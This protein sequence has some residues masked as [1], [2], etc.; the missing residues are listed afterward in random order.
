ME[1]KSL[2]SLQGKYP[3]G[4]H[5]QPTGRFEPN[6]FKVQIFSN[7]DSQ[8][9]LTQKKKQRMNKDFF[10]AKSPNKGKL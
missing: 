9:V 7:N 10:R 8:N 4:N 6:D 3:S 5:E 1:R 2:S